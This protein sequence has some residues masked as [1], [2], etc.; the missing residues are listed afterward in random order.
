MGFLW[1]LMGI[2]VRKWAITPF[3]S[4]INRVGPAIKGMTTHFLAGVNHQ[5]LLVFVS[6][7]L[8]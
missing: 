1:D 2:Q 5:V 6:D 4:G 7:M 3:S 8:S